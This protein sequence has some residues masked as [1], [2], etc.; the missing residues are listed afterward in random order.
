MRKLLIPL[1]LLI[2]T[3]VF[4]QVR[5]D[6]HLLQQAD[7]I[8]KET[9]PGGNTRQRVA[10]MYDG[11]TLSKVNKRVPVFM[12]SAD[13]TKMVRYYV[14]PNHPTATTR[15]L[16]LPNKSDTLAT[17]GD[18]TA[19]LDTVSGG[20]SFSDNDFEI[21]NQSD[22]TKKIKFSVSGVTTA[23]TRTLTV[24]NG[25]GTIARTS[26]LSGWLTGTLTANA[27]VDITNRDFIITSNLGN[28][29]SLNAVNNQFRNGA[30]TASLQV[31]ESGQTTLSSGSSSTFT[32][33]HGVT[34]KIRWD[35]SGVMS[36]N[37][38]SD[39]TGDTY[40]RNSSGNFT[41]LAK[42]SEGTLL[43]AGASV[44][45]Y[46]TFTIPNTISALS[47]FVSNSANVLTQVTPSAGQSIRVNAGG[48]AWEAYTPSSGGGITKAGNGIILAA[49]DSVVIDSVKVFDWIEAAVDTIS[50]GG[51]SVL[52]DIT[53]ATGSN[54]INSGANHQIWDWNSLTSGTG[55]SFRSSS[56]GAASNTLKV[57]S[58]EKS[59]ANA[60]SSQ[61]TTALNVSNT[62]TGTTSTNV[63]LFATAS[64]GTTNRAIQT[65]GDIYVGSGG[66]E[67][68]SGNVNFSGSN[69]LRWANNDKTITIA[70]NVMTLSTFAHTVF[71]NWNGSAYAERFRINN[72]NQVATSG[73]EYLTSL[74][75]S[76]EPTSGNATFRGNVVSGTINQTGGANGQVTFNSTT[77]TLTSAVNVT[78]FDYNPTVTSVT[79]DHLSFRATAGNMLV[80]ASSYHNYG[81][82]VG[83]SGYGFRDNSGA[84]E[85]KDSSG[86]WIA[87][88]SLGGGGI[89]GSTGS[90]ANAVPRADGT[91][92]STLKS[93]SLVVNDNGFLDV[94]VGTSGSFYDITAAG[95]DTNQ[96]IR[97]VAKGS[98]NVFLGGSSGQGTQFNG[99]AYFTS[100]M[101]PN[102]T[103]SASN[104]TIKPVTSSTP[105]ADG[106][107]IVF[108]AQD[109]A[110]GNSNGGSIILRGGDG[111]GTGY[112]GKVIVDD[113][114]AIGM[115]G[116]NIVHS[117]DSVIST[118][119]ASGKRVALDGTLPNIEVSGTSATIDA[120]YIGKNVKCTSASETDLTI[121]STLQLESVFTVTQRGNGTINLLAGSNVVINGKTSTTDQ[122]DMIWVYLIEKSG[123]ISYY[124]GR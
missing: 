49:S 90:T 54:T 57:V 121:P 91:G 19:A 52:S 120:T 86:S 70:S 2:G 124:I 38:G 4:A 32:L 113:S 8:R 111:N 6:Q 71:R 112:D 80:P 17:I 47:T 15:Y 74:T 69:G 36:L 79:G 78:G 9:T 7:T 87:F 43:R 85:Y 89:G 48:T 20:T 119:F 66:I 106:E 76:F 64:G 118:T 73:N 28:K 5:T 105:N 81:T 95:T 35:A 40:Y 11:L 33:R 59:G 103:S 77:P 41:R 110:S 13:I 25:D 50:S 53:A 46:S 94:G 21:F 83:S 44:P 82:T 24:P 55:M 104:P 26:D 114:L 88:N 123:G 67:M 65:S 93:S 99:S 39:A 62:S 27:T 23:T 68:V 58:V 84:M 75:A 63:G 45:T 117:G 29:I 56:T 101:Y 108:E 22:N 61:T 116:I 16:Y 1:L 107:Y 34:A 42:G 98:G 18:I 30:G 60:S 97:L 92:G 37:V 72:A 102:V 31:S 115:T 109:G 12:D 100:R 14:H 96:S 51:S 122:W 10:R 3:V